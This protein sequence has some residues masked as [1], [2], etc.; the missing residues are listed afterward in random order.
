MQKLFTE[1][2]HGEPQKETEIGLVPES[3]EV[4]ELG[5][6]SNIKT[7]FLTFKEIQN[8]YSH[9]MGN[10]KFLFPKVSDMNIEGN[11][12]DMNT[13]N[14]IFYTN[15]DNDFRQGFLAPNSIIFPKRGAAIKTNKK[16]ITT[17]YTVLDPNLIG[18]EAGED[19]KPSFLYYFFDRFD[20][21]ILQDNNPIP[22][23][24]KHNVASIKIPLPKINEQFKISE[25]LI[26]FEEKLTIQMAKKKLLNALFKSLLNQ[27]MTGQLRVNDI[28]FPN[29][30]VD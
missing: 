11:E 25:K 2:L 6:H 4:V 27:L 20:L 26:K 30:E 13:A 21:G 16:R 5:N 8:R 29:M 15:N 14:N 17:T 9:D 19:L 18:I 1:G 28:D 12:I 23:L 7:S 3:W 10:S 24:N 22:Q